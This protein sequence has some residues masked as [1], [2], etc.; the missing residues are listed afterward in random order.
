MIDFKSS[1]I[2]IITFLFFA[3][4]YFIFTKKIIYN[5][6]Q[7]RQ[8]STGRLLKVLQEIFGS[9]KDIKLKKSENFFEKLFGKDINDFTV[10]AYKSNT[11]KKYQDI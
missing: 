5:F 7:I 6:G 2:L 10:A 11:I 1:L 8:I 3:S 4:I 9:I